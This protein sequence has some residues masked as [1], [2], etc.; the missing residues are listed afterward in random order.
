MNT[1][2]QLFIR[3]F[4]LVLTG[5]LVGAGV[6]LF[7]RETSEPLKGQ[8]E[9]PKLYWFIPDGLRTDPDLFTLFAWA[10]QGKLPNI[11]RM[12]DQGAYGYSVPIFPSHTP[13]NYASLLTG[14][15]PKQHG[16]VDGPIRL[17]GYPLQTITQSGFSSTTKLVEPLWVTLDRLGITTTLLSVPG[18]TPPEVFS[19]QVVKG[20]WGGWGFDFPSVIF[21]SSKSEVNQIENALIKFREPQAPANWKTKMPVS[22]SPIKELVIEDW[23]S[24]LHG[25]LVD[26]QNDKKT[27]YDTIRFYG[28]KQS[29]LFSLTE[30]EWSE[31]FPLNIKYQE[32]HQSI[33]TSAKIKVIKLGPK[34]FYRVRIL[35]NGLNS[36]LVYPTSLNDVLQSQVG[37]M[38]DFPDNFPPQLIYYPEDKNTFADESRMSFDWHQK[39]LGHLLS[40]KSQDVFIHSIYAPNQMLTSRWWLPSIDPAS[41]RH[42]QIP[43]HE[44]ESAL[45]ETLQM[46]QR[47][48]AMLGE[49]LA[50][51]DL[52]KS[53]IV[54]SSDHGVIPLN[55]EVR[56][57][58]YFFKK[59]WLKYIYD[60]NKKSLR[61][62]WKNTKV[63]YLMMNHIYINPQGLEGPYNPAKGAEY[64][65]LR[66][67]VTAALSA[68]QNSAG[69]KPLQKVIPRENANEVGLAE[70]RVGDLIVVNKAGFNWSE[71]ITED[72]VVFT[73]S[74]KGG[75]KQAVDPQQRGL[76]TP[77]IIMG[78]GIKENYKIKEPISHLDQYPTIL[79]AL[80]VKPVHKTEH[81]PLNEIFR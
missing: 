64:T 10:E 50:Q 21:Q 57:N 66:G 26:T 7:L 69:E 40:H 49:A 75:Y 15:L 68:L 51:M 8:K 62:D 34:D 2:V 30:G 48:D 76:W 18:S 31:W 16:V 22:F 42:P 78:P 20:R 29:F 60:K 38:V 37:P 17:F 73:E 32:G 74:L 63:V 23:S 35:Y 71:E 56:L 77:F 13:I 39:A 47:V 72:G 5:L 54:L 4:L 12:M 67:E 53:Y 81:Q 3:R 6:Y 28:N 80:G 44:R 9:G 58:N 59:G 25:L 65:K 1:A 14:V 61:I 11:K 36:S 79:K 52:Q 24:G 43:S 33:L 46:Y 19:G 27:S 70:D 45:Q 55:F 41:S